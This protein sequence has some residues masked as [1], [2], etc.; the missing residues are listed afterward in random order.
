MSHDHQPEEDYA[1][2]KMRSARVNWPL[3]AEIWPAAAESKD[4]T[5]VRP[6][7]DVPHLNP[8]GKFEAQ[9]MHSLARFSLFLS[10]LFFAAMPFASGSD[11]TLPQGDE[12]KSV[13]PAGYDA[14]LHDEL[15]EMVKPDQAVRQK[16]LSEMAPADLELMHQTDLVHEKRM[17][18]IVT[19]YGWP[20][21]KLVGDDGSMDAWLI[22]QHSSLEFEELCLPL[23]QKAVREKD[24]AVMN[25]AY[26]LDRVRMY[27]GKPQVYGTQFK[28]YHLYQVED[29]DLLD[30]R[31]RSMGLAP[32][33]E[34]EKQIQK[35][36]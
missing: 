10:M 9:V 29:P 15:V 17:R 24:A 22:V 30:E 11:G 36:Q 5:T 25:Y 18:Q 16:R 13:H 3:F 20:G 7:I 23:V 4:A 14:A 32:E 31:R 2:T 34:Y 6:W 33:A 35:I 28:D 8:L 1:T 19:Q 12:G 26:L 21:R 27:E